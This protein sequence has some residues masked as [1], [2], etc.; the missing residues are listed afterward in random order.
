[1]RIGI[2]GGSFCPIHIGHLI[3]ADF[4]LN[5]LLLDKIIFV[6]NFKSPLKNDDYSIE[7]VH[8]LNLINLSISDNPKLTIDDF[9][10]KEKKISYSI[11]TILYLKDLYKNSNLFFLI[12]LDQFLQFQ[13]WY[14]WQDILENVTLVVAERNFKNHINISLEMEKYKNYKDKILFLKS[15]IVEIS[16]S[17]IRNNIK[18][19]KAFRYLIHPNAY[20]Y[21]I[22]YNLFQ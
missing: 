19:N 10:I 14:R 20:H 13:N 7:K 11:N 1:M 3:I 6:P 12:G 18:N 9:E 8:I 2:F 4:F 17:D 21:I 22:E 15:P 16:S 5:E